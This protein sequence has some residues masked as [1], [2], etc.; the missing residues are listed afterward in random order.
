MTHI[1]TIFIWFIL[2][3]ILGWIWETIF[4][5]LKGLK[6]D[7]RGM[8][9]GPYCPI[10][11]VGAVLDILVCGRFE[12]AVTV[13]LVCV[14]GSAVLEYATSYS[15]ERIFHAVWWDYSKMP[16]NLNGRICLPCSL[17]FGVAGIVV[18]YVLQPWIAKLT[19]IIPLVWQE[20][21]AMLFMAVFAADCALTADS[22]IALNVKLEAILSAVDNQISEKYSAFLEN[23]SKGL[24]TELGSFKNKISIEEFREHRLK[25]EVKEA[26]NVMNWGQRR[27]LRSSVSFSQRSRYEEFG[28]RMK[29]MLST[30]KK[31]T[32]EDETT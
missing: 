7:N 25:E 9:I 27:A 21:L 17:G 19:E 20:P 13:F 15:T 32:G 16:L 1:T 11:G 18:L 26:L 31:R 3:S 5:S 12:S 28:R 4:C 22:L 10:Y 23:H 30:Y 14:I 24:H 29:Q 6:W 2:Y 8:L